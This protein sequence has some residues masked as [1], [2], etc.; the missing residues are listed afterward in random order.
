M[1]REVRV[2][3]FCPCDKEFDRTAAQDGSRVLVVFGRHLEGRNAVDALSVDAENLAA[4]RKDCAA[5]ASAHENL[6]KIRRSVD[7]V[8]AIIEDQQHLLAADRI[9]DE[10]RRD[11]SSAQLQTERAGDRRGHKFGIRQR[12]KLDEPSIALECREYPAGHRRRQHG[13]PN[14]ARSRQRHHTICRH[15]VAQMLHDGLS[16][17]QSRCRNGHIGRKRMDALAARPRRIR[18]RRH[19]L[20]PDS[21]TALEPI[22]TT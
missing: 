5:W 8:L 6:D 17:H 19:V 10:S 21:P 7:H 3:S 1:R 12:S 22:A 18:A 15:Q 4:R 9:R 16:A 20:L 14:P 11:L 13:F 2:P